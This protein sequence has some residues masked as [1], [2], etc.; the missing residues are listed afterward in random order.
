M[1]NRADLNRSEKLQA[2]MT[3]FNSI[4]FNPVNTI[5]S[6]IIL[7]AAVSKIKK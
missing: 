6:E 4:Q 3:Q 1:I 2:T 5:A 7:S